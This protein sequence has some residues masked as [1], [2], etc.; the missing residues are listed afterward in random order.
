[1]EGLPPM[2][3]IV[4]PSVR[5][6]KRVQFC[7][8][9]VYWNPAWTEDENKTMFHSC[10]NRFG[11]GHN[12]ELKVCIEGPLDRETG[13]V[14]NLKDL[15]TVLKEEVIEPL[16]HRHLNAQIPFF[17][18][19]IPTLEN[20]SLFIWHRLSPRLEKNELQLCW[21]RLKENETLSVEYRGAPIPG[22]KLDRLH[23]A[24]IQEEEYR[25]AVSV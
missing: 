22:L 12:Y 18:K 15:K 25:H 14:I 1:M 2:N 24:P 16:D 20:L 3:A 13:M 11:H 23:E 10:S 9:H 17:Q 4:N 19:T 6:I 8:A 7:S 5:V 21:I